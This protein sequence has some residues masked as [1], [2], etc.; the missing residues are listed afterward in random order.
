MMKESGTLLHTVEDTLF[1][2]L[3]APGRLRL[4]LI[5]LI[6]PEIVPVANEMRE[7]YWQNKDYPP[8]EWAIK[9][10]VRV[11]ARCKECGA[12]VLER[13]PWCGSTDL[14]SPGM[15]A[16]RYCNSCHKPVN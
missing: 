15:D 14:E 2:A 11:T 4:R 16:N 8:G 3:N 6:F 10:H 5:R 1:K 13:C 12:P 7:W 9:R